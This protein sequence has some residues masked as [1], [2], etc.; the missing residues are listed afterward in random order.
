[1][2]EVGRGI[3]YPDKLTRVSSFREYRSELLGNG[4][5]P[6][7]SA[8]HDGRLDDA[9]ALYQE[10]IESRSATGQEKSVRQLG[11]R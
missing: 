8:R 11:N 10:G 9:A 6:A 2:A 7:E 4:R 3:Y 1:M 5:T